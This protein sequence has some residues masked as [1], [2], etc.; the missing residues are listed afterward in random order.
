MAVS[1]SPLNP[2]H[3]QI[4]KQLREIFLSEEATTGNDYWQSQDHLLAYDSLLG[5]RI[6]WKWDQV[7]KEMAQRKLLS[8]PTHIEIIDWGCGSGVATRRFLSFL[9]EYAPQTQIER[10]VLSDRS[11]LAVK[12]AKQKILGEFPHFNPEEIFTHLSAMTDT[13][14]LARAPF[15]IFLLSHVIGELPSDMLGRLQSILKNFADLVLW[16]DAG[17]HTLS[18][19]LSQVRDGLKSTF[20]PLAP[21]THSLA[22][23]MLENKNARH[24]CHFFTK[25]PPNVALDPNWIDA[26]NALGI[27]LRSVPYSFLIL[28]RKTQLS[29]QETLTPRQSSDIHRALG[30]PRVYKG[31]LKIQTCS[32][33]HGVNEFR[34]QKRDNA[35]LFRELSKDKRNIP[36]LWNLDGQDLS[37]SE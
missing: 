24:W 12:W 23:P 9:Q 30:R 29:L 32:Y 17:T 10:L 34:L 18:T 35:G 13:A 8:F 20:T 5:A 27:D 15:R 21:C 37:L 19:K 36:A 28:K 31:Y 3:L 14:P 7:L 4:L 6:G 33:N 16:V 2:H 1:A 25:I 22:C 11:E 26:A